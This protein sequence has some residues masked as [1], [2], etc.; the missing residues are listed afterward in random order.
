[1]KSLFRALLAAL[2][3]RRL[4]VTQSASDAA[5]PPCVVIEA[6]PEPDSLVQRLRESG[7]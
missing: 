5:P 1:M 3:F 7:L 4:F 6:S 2:D